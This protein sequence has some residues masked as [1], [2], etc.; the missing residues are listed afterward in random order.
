MQ[1]IINVSDVTV[2]S[3]A[4]LEQS[5]SKS[6]LQNLCRTALARIE[7]LRETLNL[8]SDAGVDSIIANEY[9][10]LLFVLTLALCC[11][12]RKQVFAVL[13]L[14]QT[15]VKKADGRY[16]IYVTGEQSKD[17]KSVISAI[18]QEL[19]LFYDFYFTNV[20]RLLVKDPDAGFVFPS[21]SGTAQRTDFSKWTR[22]VTL[23]LLGREM[24]CHSFRKS[25]VSLFYY[26]LRSADSDMT[27]LAALM[28]HTV[29]TQQKYYLRQ[30]VENDSEVFNRRIAECVLLVRS[31][32]E[33]LQ[34]EQ[35]S[36]LEKKRKMKS[37]Y[38]W[39]AKEGTT[40]R[41]QCRKRTGSL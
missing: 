9:V 21:D 16:W 19:T 28:N 13:K 6:E 3:T 23:Q 39:N 10:R 4:I 40:E 18:S 25:I 38:L 5:L 34:K 11:T 15:L 33:Q 35:S 41:K 31:G 14:H 17:G 24:T 1:S 29:Q 8:K 20:R 12:P 27:K 26:D 37:D 36:A 7:R 22:S 32:P 30:Q 2:S